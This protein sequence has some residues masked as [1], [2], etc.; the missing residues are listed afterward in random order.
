MLISR[1][2]MHYWLF[3]L[4]SLMA[5]CSTITEKEQQRIELID[6]KTILFY[7]NTSLDN[8]ELLKNILQDADGQADT[9]LVNSNGGD[10][11]G[12]IEIG[13]A[14]KQYRLKVV[15]DQFCISSCANYIATA[16]H[17]VVVR[18]GGLLGWHGGATQPIYSPL[19]VNISWLYKVKLFLGF[20]S[21]DETINEFNLKFLKKEI[22]F[23]NSISVKQAVTVI[24]MMPSYKQRR[25]APS[26]SY[27]RETLKRLGLTIRFEDEIPATKNQDG[28]KYV[29]F[30]SL[31]SV[32]L[33]RLLERHQQ[34]V[35]EFTESLETG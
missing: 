13:K 22:K 8:A 12:G 1:N 10:V 33:D 19:K 35:K 28:V 32:E 11:L 6:E 9:L 26:F 34:L 25:N 24:G 14:I 2:R 3:I 31:S 4:I 21:I 17:D 30:F 29:Q 23:F 16:S 15:I 20:S 5:G 7:G 18:K 27:D